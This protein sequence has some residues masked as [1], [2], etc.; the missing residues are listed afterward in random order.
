V[1]LLLP[2]VLLAAVGLI[3]FAFIETEANYQ[4]YYMTVNIFKGGWK[5][6]FM[7]KRSVMR[8]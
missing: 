7:G 3:L 6:I 2:G 1:L 8:K 4:V 5:A